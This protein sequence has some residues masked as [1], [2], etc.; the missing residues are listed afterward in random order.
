MSWLSTLETV[1]FPCLSGDTLNVS[2]PVG[3]TVGVQSTQ[4]VNFMCNLSWTPHSSLEKDNFVNHSCVSPK[5]DCLELTI[6]NVH[7]IRPVR[8]MQ[9]NKIKMVE[10][11]IF[12]QNN[13]FVSRKM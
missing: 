13:L 8:I 5:V 10:T 4:G 6:K 2:M 12:S 7:K 3:L 11:I 1:L 9:T